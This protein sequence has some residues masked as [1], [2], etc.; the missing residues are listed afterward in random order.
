LKPMTGEEYMKWYAEQCKDFA[1]NVFTLVGC[2]HLVYERCTVLFDE[3]K[4]VRI[5]QQHY[6]PETRHT[7]WAEVDPKL[8]SLI[9]CQNKSYEWFNEKA[10]PLDSKVIPAYTIRQ[11]MWALRVK[12]MPKLPWETSFD[13][14]P[15]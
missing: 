13:H 15:I 4:C 10:V 5:V 7:W 12:P 1:V 2:S 6:N 8:L 3:K 14:S 11:V 9:C